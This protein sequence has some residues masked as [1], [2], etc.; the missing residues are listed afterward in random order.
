MGL[1][2]ITTT[3]LSVGSVVEEREQTR[4]A[5]RD[6]RRAQAA[7]RRI[8][9]VRAARERRQ[10]IRQARTARAQIESGA[11]ASGTS[12]TSGAISGAAGVTTQLASNLSFLNQQQSLANQQSLFAQNA[13]D[14]ESRAQEMAG[15]RNLAFQ[16]ASLFTPG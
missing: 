1:D 4:A 2:P 10:A 9:N 5:R 3:V 7:E 11:V 12:N 13:A 6:A 15:Y 8:Q 16:T 14:H